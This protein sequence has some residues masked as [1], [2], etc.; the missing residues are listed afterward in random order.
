MEIGTADCS[1][2]PARSRLAPLGVGLVGVLVG[3]IV[4]ALLDGAYWLASGALGPVEI[5]PATG[6]YLALAVPLAAGVV[7]FLSLRKGVLTRSK[8]A[9][10]SA[11]VLTMTGVHV[12]VTASHWVSM[13]SLLFVVIAVS[14]AL[15]L[16]PS[17]QG[18]RAASYSC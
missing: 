17:A 18:E 7:T 8:V 14:T 3:L 5:D 13:L 10:V 11:A 15:V 6:I 2:G 1:T 9:F 4:V 12:L 16:A